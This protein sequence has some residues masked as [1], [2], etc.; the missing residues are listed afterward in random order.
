MPSG[1]ENGCW[2]EYGGKKGTGVEKDKERN[3]VDGNRKRGNEKVEEI[4]CQL[5]P[6]VLCVKFLCIWLGGKG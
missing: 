2:R 6:R 5:V 1:S 3:E 4:T